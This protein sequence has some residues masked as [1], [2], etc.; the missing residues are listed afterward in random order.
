MIKLPI[1]VFHSGQWDDTNSCLNYKTTGVLVDEMICG[2]AYTVVDFEIN[3]R[4]IESTY[5]NIRDYLSKVNGIND[6]KFQM[7]DGRKQFIVQLDCK[8]CTYRIWDLDEIPCAHALAVRRWCNF[9]QLGTML[10]GKS[11]GI[12]MNI[13]PPT[14]KRR[15]GRLRTQRILSIG[16]KKSHS[17]CSLCHRA[18][19]LFDL[20]FSIFFAIS[21][22]VKCPRR[23][24]AANVLKMG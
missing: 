15:V 5:P 11:I 23:R 2:K 6:V 22:V 19:C 17:R 13:L 3:M 24:G 18:D 12:D 9:I 20:A 10:I 16:E 7:I 1:V 8:S 21:I 14:F 4:W